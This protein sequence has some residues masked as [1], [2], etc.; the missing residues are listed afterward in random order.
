M[1]S[2]AKPQT[3]SKFKVGQRVAVYDSRLVDIRQVGV[4]ESL[5]DPNGFYKSVLYV[6]GV[7][8]R[9]TYD[10]IIVSTKQCRRL[11]GKS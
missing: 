2:K 5:T 1:K 8:R 10:G 11:K 9:D 7:K 4:V 3:K 6:V